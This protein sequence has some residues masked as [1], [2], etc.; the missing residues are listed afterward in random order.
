ML[1]SLPSV[2]VTTLVAF[3][4][5][6]PSLRVALLFGAGLVILVRLGWRFAS[7]LFDRERLI[8]NSK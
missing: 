5:I 7:S 4:V 1:A 3:D 2:A 8:T 6:H